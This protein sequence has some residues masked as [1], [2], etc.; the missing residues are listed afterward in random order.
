MLGFAVGKGVRKLSHGEGRPWFPWVSNLCGGSYHTVLP[1]SFSSRNRRQSYDTNNFTLGILS[2][3]LFL[4]PSTS[5]VY[6]FFLSYIFASGIPSYYL[7]Y[8]TPL[9]LY[10]C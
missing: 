1:T 7:F 3:S 9:H 5:Y 6:L 2:F 4:H 8:F 10:A